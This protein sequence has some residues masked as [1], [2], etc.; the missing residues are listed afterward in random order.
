MAKA[1]IITDTH[2]GARN[3]NQL[4]NE[5]FEKFY[6]EVFFPYIKKHNIKTIFHLGDIMDRRKFINYITLDKFKKMFIKQAM[7][8]ELD[9][10]I[11]LGNHDVFYRNTNEINAIDQLFNGHEYINSGKMKF[12]SKTTEIVFDGTKLLFVPWINSSNY[13]ES[14]ELIQ[15]TDAQ[16]LFGHLELSGFDMYRGMKNMHGMDTKPFSKFELVASGHF[17]HKSTKGNINYLGCPYEINWNDYNDR[18]GFHIFDSDKRSLTFHQNPYKMFFKVWYDDSEKHIEEII[19]STDF[20]RFKDRIVKIVVQNKT[21]S[22]WFDLF[23]D[24]IYK[25]SPNHVT[26]IEENR[27]LENILESEIINE[28]EDTLTILNNYIKALELSVDRPA[29]QKELT[30]LYMDAQKMDII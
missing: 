8:L 16:I 24:K 4:F 3:D 30:S 7:E 18:R 14:I 1:A 21:N 29:L 5:Y 19:E 13:Q 6:S 2:F 9:L 27:Q 20:T 12:Y 10:H 17:H 23:L 11:I 28:A 22:Y 25:E 15:S 26:I